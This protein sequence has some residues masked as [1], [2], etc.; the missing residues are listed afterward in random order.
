[1]WSRKDSVVVVVK[2][3]KGALADGWQPGKDLPVIMVSAIGD[4]VPAMDGVA[5]VSDEL[6][7]NPAAFY[8]AFGLAAK[9]LA[10]AFAV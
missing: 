3:V 7:G 2:A 1:M 10:A 4:L 5:L 6:K 8:A 9:D